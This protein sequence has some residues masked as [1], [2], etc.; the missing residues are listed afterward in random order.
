MAG[1]KEKVKLKPENSVKKMGCCHNNSDRNN[2]DYSPKYEGLLT[3]ELSW[4]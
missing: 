2:S 3:E 1:E 4:E